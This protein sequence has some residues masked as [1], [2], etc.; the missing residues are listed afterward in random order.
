MEISEVKKF[1]KP[2]R[3]AVPS[4]GVGTKRFAH[5]THASSA[6]VGPGSYDPRL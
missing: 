4:F 5:S 3:L 6:Q 2:T 1:N